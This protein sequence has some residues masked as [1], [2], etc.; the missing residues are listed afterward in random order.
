VT[1]STVGG[2]NFFGGSGLHL[3]YQANYDQL[4]AAAAAAAKKASV[5]IVVVADVTS[6]GMDRSTLALPAD[7]DQLIAA[8]AAVNPRT[9]VILN[10]SGAVLMPWLKDVHAVIANWYGGQEQGHAV[11]AMLFGDAEPGGRLPETFP[12][13]DKQGPAKTTVEFPGDGVDVYYDEELAIGYRWYESSG[14]KPLFPFGYGLS[15]TT[16]AM[17]DLRVQK[18]NGG[19][20]AS[21]TVRNTGH[22]TGSE[23]VQL[24]VTAP[25]GSGEPSRQLKAFAKVTLEAG[26]HEVVHLDVPRAALAVW[27]SVTEGWTVRPGLYHVA[28][29]NSVASL[30]LKTQINVT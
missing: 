18:V 28:V 7:Q 1:Y 2:S 29:G 6:E 5:A 9:V 22:R 17:T 14:E 16:F 3:G 21:V 15:Y 30:P 25:K 20:R 27:P 4:I 11:A 26:R 19:L 24:Y 23:V 10:T 12:A 8:V 13:S